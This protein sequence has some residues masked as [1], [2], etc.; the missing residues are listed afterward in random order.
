M[1]L[2]IFNY[3]P[4]NST[5]LVLGANRDEYY[6]RETLPAHWWQDN[7][8]QGVL[9]GRDG[10]AGGTWLGVNRQRHLAALTNYRD[11]SLIFPE[12]VSRGEIVS[13]F[14]R[15]DCLLSAYAYAQKI[16]NEVHKYNPY[17]LIL[18]DGQELIYFSSVLKKIEKLSAGLYTLSN[19]HL[20]SVWHK[21]IKMRIGWQKIANEINIKKNNYQKLFDLLSDSEIAED[22]ILPKTGIPF[23]REKALSAPFIRTD[24]YGTR[25]QSV[26]VID[27]ELMFIERQTYPQILQQQYNF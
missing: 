19:A 9:A 5:P 4:Q 27:K 24:D 14:L 13:N 15:P 25:S 12:R 10:S 2:L 23:A 21:T 16:T 20:D 11:T 3:Q 6:A 18:F 17:N 1:C 22:N 8:H 26:V 7:E